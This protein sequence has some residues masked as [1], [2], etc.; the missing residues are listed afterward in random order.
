MPSTTTTQLYLLG[1]LW[2]VEIEFTYDPSDPLSNV[3]D[4]IEINEVWL[5]G[6]YPEGSGKTDDYV[7]CHIKADLQCFN[8]ADDDACEEAVRE[9]IEAAAREAFDYDHSYED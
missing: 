6:Y 9:Y 2:K 3:A 1:T 7:A 5:L 4:N 8:R